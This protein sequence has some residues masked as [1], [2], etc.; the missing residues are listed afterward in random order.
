[1]DGK[2]VALCAL[3]IAGSV[4]AAETSQLLDATAV[5]KKIETPPAT[6]AVAA[7]APAPAEQLLKDI[8]A[9]R[10]QAATMNPR[11][12][13][14]TWFSLYDRAKSLDLKPWNPDYRLYDSD[15]QRSVST[16][17]VLLA[18]PPPSAWPALRE[19]AKARAMRSPQAP[20]VVG[21]RLLTELLTHDRA[22]A[23]I[24]LKQIETGAANLSPED[25]AALLA[26]VSRTRTLLAELYG[27]PEE[28]VS[29]FISE[30]RA[31]V[32]E[33]YDSVYP[34]Q[35]PDLVGLVGEARATQLLGD[36][37]TGGGLIQVESGAA[38]RALARKIALERVADMRIPQWAL[39]DD[40][41]AADLYLALQ[42]RFDVVPAT[43][44]S[45]ARPYPGLSY[46]RDRADLYYFLAMVARGNQSAAES[47][48]LR[49]ANQSFAIPKEAVAALEKAGQREALYRVLHEAL[50]KHP[51]LRAWKVY[52]EQAAY[53]GHA[54]DAMKRIDTVLARPGLPEYLQAELRTQ[55]IGVLLARD[56]IEPATKALRDLLKAPPANSERDLETRIDAATRLV[57]LGRVL[58][59]PEFADAGLGFLHAVLQLPAS[60][61]ADAANSEERERHDKVLRAVFAAERKLG[62]LA[63]AQNDAL[64]ALQRR[65]PERNQYEQFGL[66]AVEPS[67]VLAMSEL[68]GLYA[69]TGRY[70][71][72]VTLLDESTQWGARD[73]D[74]L[75]QLP[76]SLDVPV[77]LSAARALAATGNDAAALRLV[78]AVL[79]T[80]PGYDPAY[81]LL[82]QIDANALQTLDALYRQD[83]FE[84]RPLIWT[85]VLHKSRGQLDA[86]LATIRRAVAI[87]PSDG[88]EGV[89]DRMRA[90]SV[91]ADILEAKG[92]DSDAA[93]SRGAVAAIRISERSDELHG[94][95]LYQRAFAGYREAL[96]HFQDAYCI[97]SRLAVQL[98][99]QGRRAEALDHYKRAYELMPES[100]GRVESHCFGCE[101]VFQ[102][103]EQQGIAEE[104][105]TRIAAKTPN[106]PQAHYLL[107]Y[108]REEQRRYADALQPL[109]TAVSLDPDYLNAWKH[110]YALADK[111]YM[112]A[113][114]RDIARM[115]L[116][117]L[118][119]RQLHVQY[120]LTKV[121]DL[122]ALWRA[123]EKVAAAQQP[124]QMATLYPLRRSAKFY[125]DTLAQLP[126]NI[127]AQ[128]I[129]YQM[130]VKD[131]STRSNLPTPR[132]AMASHE[133]IASAAQIMGITGAAND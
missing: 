117:E 92:E 8:V 2:F 66:E 38:T 47:T 29:T 114:E 16:G 74:K 69:S 27:T 13:A 25:R 45:T 5:L 86:A 34:V 78:K 106:N 91:L 119:P 23:E 130:A 22:A 75:V 71:D 42:R 43:G 87:D 60:D 33:Q 118:D 37:V 11:Q 21:A 113:G 104:V 26:P 54:D 72:L 6:A 126:E 116:L 10:A 18:L 105:F 19:E 85:A 73:L 120:E 121:S 51:E 109:R 111:V 61:G 56:D 35:V 63:A 64:E 39:V 49:I 32:N 81:E 48:L 12:S 14:T 83:P 53:T 94:L 110:L 96:T 50:G 77:A 103:N 67:R 31:S 124:P 90:Y 125:D 1:M 62:R 55:R 58:S 89:N 40:I 132:A 95:G 100:F 70:Q 76:D 127:R 3:V 82:V 112:D 123:V 59:K 79:A 24:S 17:S 65:G 129:L 107:G 57:G 93:V 4:S 98:A 88:E 133:L 102:G 41:E 99:Q 20:E 84:E 7:R 52:V 15:S 68:A 97:Q 36:L 30:H 28:I 44:A 9:F 46:A 131:L 108:L 122:A 128:M 80:R 101:S 115:R